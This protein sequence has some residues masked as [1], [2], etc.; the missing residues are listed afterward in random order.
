MSLGIKD[1]LDNVM[2]NWWEKDIQPKITS[3]GTPPQQNVRVEVSTTSFTKTEPIPAP[4]KENT[5]L[6]SDKSHTNAGHV[7]H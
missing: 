5:L 6:G 2:M 4:K 7:E 1:A 3:R